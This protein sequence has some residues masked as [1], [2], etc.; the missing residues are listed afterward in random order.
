MFNKF[1]L[2]HICE[3][4]CSMC[5]GYSPRSGWV[6]MC[7]CHFQILPGYLVQ[8]EGLIALV[9]QGHCLS[10]IISNNTAC[11]QMSGLEDK[12]QPCFYANVALI[13][14]FSF[15]VQTDAYL[16]ISQKAEF[17]ISKINFWISPTSKKI[18]QSKFFTSAKW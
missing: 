13:C 10:V 7:F 12:R 18:L 5:E 6:N 15:E 17:N 2:L 3:N 14:T 11:S 1:V 16:D 8:R 4:I 9:H